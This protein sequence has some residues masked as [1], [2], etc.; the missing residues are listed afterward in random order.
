MNRSLLGRL[1]RRIFIV[2]LIG[3]GL[4]GC[5]DRSPNTFSV[6]DASA[7]AAKAGAGGAGA[8]GRAGPV[9]MLAV[10]GRLAVGVGLGSGV[11]QKGVELGGGG[12]GGPTAGSG[13]AAGAVAGAGGSA[14]ESGVAGAGGAAGAS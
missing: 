2:P 4:L 7:D 6:P 11:W 1:G 5:K 3:W 8:A 13:G 12:A 10:A 14:G 9:G